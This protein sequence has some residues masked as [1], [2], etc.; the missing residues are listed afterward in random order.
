MFV[1]FVWLVK[2]M[3]PINAMRTARKFSCWLIT[4]PPLVMNILY[5]LVEVS[6]KA[7]TGFR[8]QVEFYQEYREVAP[9]DNTQYIL[10]YKILKEKKGSSLQSRSRFW[11]IIRRKNLPKNGLT[12][13][14]NC[15]IRMVTKR[16]VWSFAT[17]SFSGSTRVT[18]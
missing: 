14:P 4:E 5:R 1:P 6:L 12:S 10:K 2:S 17:R 11:R 7:G 16:N 18:T 15:T 3:L 9:N 13:L 8:S